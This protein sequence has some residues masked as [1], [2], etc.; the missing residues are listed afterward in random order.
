LGDQCNFAHSGIAGMSRIC[1]HHLTGHCKLGDKCDFLH[2]LGVTRPSLPA[3]PGIPG[4][5]PGLPP[6][7]SSVHGPLHGPPS[8]NYQFTQP[9]TPSY[10]N[11]SAVP[12]Y[13]NPSPVPGYGNPSPVPGYSG[14]SPPSMNPYNTSLPGTGFPPPSSYPPSSYNG[15]SPS[16]SSILQTPQQ[17]GVGKGT[18][19]CKHWSKGWCRMAE[20]CGFSHE[21]PP[22][23]ATG[24]ITSGSFV[25]KKICRHWEK[26][27]TCW[28]GAQCT[29]LHGKAT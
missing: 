2:D 16:P 18:K 10:G 5:L 24:Q 27:G 23:A 22:G 17:S 29:F 19:P 12:G 25:P 28:M 21:G 3:F 14:S 20:G 26:N 13:G 6:M 8:G 7:P 9:L 11:P 4:A 15:Y 1:K